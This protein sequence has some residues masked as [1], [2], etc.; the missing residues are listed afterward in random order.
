VARS[1]LRILS[2]RAVFRD[3]FRRLRTHIH[4]H[5]H[6]LT[7]TH[8][9]RH[10][11]RHRDRHRHRHRHRHTYT[12][13]LSL[14]HTHKRTHTHTHTRTHTYKVYLAASQKGDVRGLS[15][16][17]RDSETTRHNFQ[18][19]MCC[20]VFVAS[21]N[22]QKGHEQLEIRKLQGIIFKSVCVVAFYSVLQCVAV[23]CIV[24]PVASQ[25]AFQRP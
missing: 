1:R 18:E 11:H 7:H 22:S 20:S 2:L 23:Q 16:V 24:Y 10:R 6:T 4:S 3:E 21:N 15:R 25:K 9:H 17:V 13:S 8:G 19:C 14:I 5:T 12:R